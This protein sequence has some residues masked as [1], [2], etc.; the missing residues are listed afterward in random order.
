MGMESLNYVDFLIYL[1]RNALGTSESYCVLPSHLMQVRGLKLSSQRAKKRDRASHL[2]Q[3]RG[4][5]QVSRISSPACKSHLT[6]VRGLKPR[7]PKEKKETE[8]NDYLDR[9]KVIARRSPIRWGM[10]ALATFLWSIFLTAS[11]QKTPTPPNKKL[12]NL[13]I[14]ARKLTERNT[15]YATRPLRF[16]HIYTTAGSS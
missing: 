2:T 1:E 7:H 9:R 11:F 15:N 13:I 3:V 8:R 16:P 6:Q 14:E 12:Y 4:L 5:K 10:A